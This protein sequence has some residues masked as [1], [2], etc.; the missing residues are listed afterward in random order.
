MIMFPIIF[1][2]IPDSYDEYGVPT[3]EFTQTK[4]LRHYQ[5]NVL[6]KNTDN[7]YIS[8]IDEHLFQWA[9]TQIIKATSNGKKLDILEVGGG[10]GC[11]YDRVKKV[12][13]K[14][15]NIEP[16][17]LEYSKSTLER[18]ANEN[19]SYIKCSAEVIPLPD[20][21]VD[22]VI[23]IASLDHIPD[24]ISTIIEARR[25]L[26][27]G[28]KFILCFNNRRSWW[29]IL[30]KN[31]KYLKSRHEIISNEHYF[32]WSFQEAI[33]ML[34]IHFENVQAET[35]IFI[36]FISYIWRFLLPIANF[37]GPT[38]LKKYGGNI[39]LVCEKNLS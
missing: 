29:K 3:F 25:L 9:S 38:L 39:C 8:I 14:Y 16:G 34:S 23:S 17:I 15:Y 13:S 36:P 32:L 37:F 7:N 33:D 26:R 5:N 31:T 6:L 22:I 1:T 21:S 10:N 35:R 30:L 18:I 4:G 24:Y 28:G 20:S 27:K 2:Q 19:Y 12:T 11:F